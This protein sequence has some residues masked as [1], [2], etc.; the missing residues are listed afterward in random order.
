MV[1][2]LLL[3]LALLCFSVV[4]NAYEINYA[5]AVN[6]SG[7]PITGTRLV[8]LRLYAVPTG[9]SL[10]IPSQ[11][12][13]VQI[14][15]GVIQT[16]LDTDAVPWTGADRWVGISINNG[17]EI[18]PRIKVRWAPYAIRAEVANRLDNPPLIG[19]NNNTG[20]SFVTS[21][22][23]TKIDSVSFTTTGL[24]KAVITACGYVEP[25]GSGSAW[26]IQY[27]ISPNSNPSHTTMAGFNNVGIATSPTMPVS[28]TQFFLI[29]SLGLQKY[30]LWAKMFGGTL[31]SLHHHAPMVYQFTPT[32]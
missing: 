10:L 29:E 8:T 31:Q 20:T 28:M 16:H 5:G 22:A 2:R 32:P 18:T 14:V 3:T 21:T 6:E 12:D 23:W 1:R 7:T 17:A 9:G 25:N 30:Y 19:S 4:A 26:G 27:A 24:G 15:G 11:S 13:S